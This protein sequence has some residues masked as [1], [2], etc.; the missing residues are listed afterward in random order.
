MEFC[1]HQSI[2]GGCQYTHLTYESELAQ[3]REFFQKLLHSLGF[4]GHIK[5]ISHD[6]RGHRVR[7]DFTLLQGKMG[8]FERDSRET[9]DLRRC[10]H[11][12]DDLHKA[13]EDF[14]KLH[15]SFQ[16]A[17]FRLR[18]NSKKEKGLWLDISNLDVKGL[19]ENRP[20]V[21]DLLHIFP[22]VEV[23]QRFKTLAIK[24][25]PRLLEFP[26]ETWFETFFQKHNIL[27]KTYIGGFTQPSLLYNK[28]IIEHL[29][30]WTQN[31]KPQHT[32]ELGAGI[33]NLSFPL[34]TNSN[35]LTAF[36][37]SGPALEGFSATLESLPED[38]QKEFD[39]RLKIVQGDF[40]LVTSTPLELLGTHYDLI[41]CNPPRS[42][43]MGFATTIEKLR[44]K[45]LIYM[46]CY[47]E[48]MEKDLQI[49][50]ANYAIEEASLVDQFPRSKHYEAL[51][52]LKRI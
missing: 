42:G 8:F 27:L 4:R 50:K 13:F 35:R 9:F 52:L 49:L 33:G 10:Q 32:L 43:L 2:C 16:K 5:S 1:Q 12:T 51:I 26:P 14:Q 6:G 47:P 25:R 18:V 11:W 3:K 21:E 41:F 23:G 20:L 24:E 37:N 30:T 44:P 45:N 28:K 36:E 29:N 39:E 22:R 7:T 15:W 38:L 46:S 17:S 48:S 19:L 34:L 40:Q 31:L